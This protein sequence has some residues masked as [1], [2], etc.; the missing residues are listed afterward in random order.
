MPNQEW[1]H[2]MHDFMKHGPNLTASAAKHLLLSMSAQ[3][4]LPCPAGSTSPSLPCSPSKQVHLCC[5]PQLLQQPTHCRPG[6]HL[7][8]TLRL[9]LHHIMIVCMY[10]FVCMHVQR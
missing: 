1:Q 10:V 4:A 2:S 8:R 3:G 9:M 7:T 6:L 5:G